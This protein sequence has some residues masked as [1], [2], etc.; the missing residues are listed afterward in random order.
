MPEAHGQVWAG[1]AQL[2]LREQDRQGPA[3]S[4]VLTHH[5]RHRSTMVLG[6][7]T[8]TKTF[9]PGEL[10]LRFKMNGKVS[11][12]HL[13]SFCRVPDIL[14]IVRVFITRLLQC[15]YVTL[16]ACH[17]HQTPRWI[18]LCNPVSTT[19]LQLNPQQVTNTLSCPKQRYQLQHSC[20]EGL[21]SADRHNHSVLTPASK[22]PR[23]SHFIT[24]AAAFCSY[25]KHLC[26]ATVRR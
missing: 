1:K 25:P 20:S 18:T 4:I 15:A 16:L 10:Y 8:G 5:H 24:K 2:G 9:L 19:S 14:R 21:P 26:P 13:T 22:R 11:A 3:R 6:K 7:F 23:A 12:G 17:S